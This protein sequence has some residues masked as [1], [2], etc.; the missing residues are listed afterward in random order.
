MFNGVKLPPEPFA[1]CDN[2]PSFSNTHVNVE[3]HFRH[4][5]FQHLH[6][7]KCGIIEKFRTRVS[8]SLAKPK[9]SS[10]IF[11]RIHFV[12]SASTWACK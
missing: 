1:A 9:S 4:V 6:N 2:R 10:L 3:F 7:G 12:P 8:L 11:L 5:S